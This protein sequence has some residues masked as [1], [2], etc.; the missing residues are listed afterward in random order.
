MPPY[1][2]ASVSSIGNSPNKGK[3]M[4]R[5]NKISQAIKG[6]KISSGGKI[7]TTRDKISNAVSRLDL[8][9]DEKLKVINELCVAAN[10]YDKAC[11]LL[12]VMRADKI[13]Y[14]L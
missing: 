7:P 1:G 14:A 11:E 3:V 6:I 2:C 10:K 12:G 8:V 9:P 4:L 5:S 13:R